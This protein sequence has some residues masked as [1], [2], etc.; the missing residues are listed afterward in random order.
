MI[1]TIIQQTVN[2]HG[3]YKDACWSPK[4]KSGCITI[5]VGHIESVRAR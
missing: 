1:G 2:S 3:L 4:A 5:D